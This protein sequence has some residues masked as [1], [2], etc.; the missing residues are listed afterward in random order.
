[1]PK[2]T[3]TKDQLY[4][5]R[6][7]EA[8]L[9]SSRE[10]YNRVVKPHC[11]RMQD[12]VGSEVVP[13]DMAL[14]AEDMMDLESEV[15]RWKEFWGDTDWKNL[16]GSVTVKE[17]EQHHAIGVALWQQLK[18]IFMDESLENSDGQLHAIY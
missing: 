18:S 11:Q 16:A 12:N 15:A 6:H 9:A 14:V 7:Q 1:M 13:Y 3:P 4:H 2:V 10:Y 17:L 5:Q 8:R